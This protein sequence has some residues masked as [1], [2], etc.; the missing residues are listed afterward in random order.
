M[1]S[2][3]GSLLHFSSKI[4]VPQGLQK[5]FKGTV[6]ASMARGLAPD[7]RPMFI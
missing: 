1:H 3:H 2:M 5:A 7:V 6:G 4:Q